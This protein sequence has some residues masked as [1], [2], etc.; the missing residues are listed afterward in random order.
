MY[1]E[2]HPCS[3]RYLSSSKACMII[4]PVI[5]STRRTILPTICATRPTFI[6]SR[7]TCQVLCF[8]NIEDSWLDRG[9]CIIVHFVLQF[10]SFCLP[11]T[12]LFLLLFHY[13]FCCF[14]SSSSS[15]AFLR[16]LHDWVPTV[17]I[18]ENLKKKALQ[19][20][21]IPPS[22]HSKSLY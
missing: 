2:L 4:W 13:F 6:L 20:C 19:N 8:T 21:I 1:C 11:N 16:S 9:N 5:S 14:S 22:S 10:L 7:N 3:R 15:V 17:N 18:I 12:L